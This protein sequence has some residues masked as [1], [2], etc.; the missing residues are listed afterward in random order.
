MAAEYLWK[1]FRVAHYPPGKNTKPKGRR[2]NGP[3]GPAMG[4]MPN[5][6]GVPRLTES[7][8]FD[9]LHE[10]L[11]K[12]LNEIQEDGWDIFSVQPTDGGGGI[13]VVARKFYL[14]SQGQTKIFSADLEG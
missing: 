10:L 14:D 7:Q 11:E 8:K 1:V 4:T 9:G 2:A 12:R 3:K 13:N 5:D 6:A